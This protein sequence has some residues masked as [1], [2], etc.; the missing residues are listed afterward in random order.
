MENSYITND[1][2]E[3]KRDG[4]Y[5]PRA[6]EE[7]KAEIKDSFGPFPSLLTNERAEELVE[8]FGPFGN[9]R[10]SSS[11][12][13]SNSSSS[14]PFGSVTLFVLNVLIDFL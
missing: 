13:S 2:N 9:K 7:N 10:P 3:N 6:F 12:S 1:E 14:S 5:N 8:V 11:S 4:G